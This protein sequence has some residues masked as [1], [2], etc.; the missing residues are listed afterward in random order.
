MQRP[1]TNL[2]LALSSPAW[3]NQTK[4]IDQEFVE[5]LAIGAEVRAPVAVGA[6]SNDISRTVWTAVREA[7]NMVT[8]DVPCF[9]G[10]L[11]RPHAPAM[12]ALSLR[13]CQDIVSDVSTP[14]ENGTVC[15][16]AL[17][18]WLSRFVR[19]STK[20]FQVYLVI[21]GD[22]VDMIDVFC[23]VA[24]SPKFENDGIS[25][26]FFLIGGRA[27]VVALIHHLAFISQPTYH[28]CEKVDGF[29][30]LPRLNDS[31]IPSLHYH[32]A[33]LSLAKILEDAV[34]PPAVYIAVFMAFLTADEE[35]YGSV[36]RRDDAAASLPIVDVV[37]IRGAVVNL[38][39]NK[40]H[41]VL[42]E[43]VPALIG[44]ISLF[45]VKEAA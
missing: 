23:D 31:A 45:G 15:R 25:Y 37:D 6:N 41:A 20:L 30:G 9:V 39:N 8:L 12:F 17:W 19:S 18:R 40:R 38:A 26:G 24:D 4:A 42:A 1:T 21:R 16:D 36:R 2:A 14:R 34:W 3:L 44:C 22:W 10:P 11:E 43:M 5:F 7:M 13:S 29:A 27:D 35:N 28:R 32:M 33:F